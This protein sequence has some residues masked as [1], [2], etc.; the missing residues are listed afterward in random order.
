MSMCL[1]PRREVCGLSPSAWNL[2]SVAFPD[3]TCEH[4]RRHP[5]AQNDGSAAPRGLDARHRLVG[6]RPHGALTVCVSRLWCVYLLMRTCASLE[7]RRGRRGWVPRCWR[8]RWAG[9]RASMP[10]RRQGRC[11]PPGQPDACAVPGHPCRSEPSSETASSRIRLGSPKEWD[12]TRSRTSGR[13]R[14]RTRRRYATARPRTPGGQT[15]QTGLLLTR[16]SRASLQLTLT[17]TL[18]AALALTLTQP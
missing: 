2:P 5:E 6:P 16:V 11:M 1:A 7:F 17:L 14:R 10:A 15:L 9:S 13:R 8:V 4:L 12:G 18:T 3:I